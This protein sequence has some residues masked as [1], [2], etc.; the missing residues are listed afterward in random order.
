MRCGITEKQT[1][2]EG[3]TKDDLAGPEGGLAK[4]HPIVC[5]GQGLT[6][7]PGN[8]EL[9][10]RAQKCENVLGDEQRQVIEVVK[11]LDCQYK[12]VLDQR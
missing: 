9:P 5:P 11:D 12:V 4:T 3:R 1:T 8:G 2:R 10:C 6:V 7:C